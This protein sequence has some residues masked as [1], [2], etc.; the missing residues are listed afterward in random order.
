MSKTQSLSIKRTKRM[1]EE[2]ARMKEARQRKQAKKKRQRQAKRQRPPGDNVN[3]DKNEYNNDSDD[4]AATTLRLTRPA[5]YNPLPRTYAEFKVKASDF[6]GHPHWDLCSPQE[7]YTWTRDWKWAAKLGHYLPEHFLIPQP[8]TLINCPQH[9]LLDT[10]H[11]L[12]ENPLP[13]ITTQTIEVL[14]E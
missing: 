6:I 1:E 12:Y 10:Q 4:D 8:D 2:I 14:H 11:L 3:I 9:I 13:P 5:T 7:Y